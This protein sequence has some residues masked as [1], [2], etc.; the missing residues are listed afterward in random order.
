[1]NL[2]LITEAENKHY[3]LIKDFNKFM[4]NQTKHK[5]RKNFCMYCLQCFSSEDILT[6]HKGICIAING[7]QAIKMPEKV[8][9]YISKTTTNSNGFHLLILKALLEK[10]KAVG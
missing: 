9:K 3:V 8:K 2:Q 5:E 7:E 4:Y 1:M 6:R 10:Y